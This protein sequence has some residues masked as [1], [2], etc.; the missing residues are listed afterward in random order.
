MARNLDL[1]DC[2]AVFVELSPTNIIEQDLAA[3]LARRA[4]PPAN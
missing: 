2:L 4:S 3:G 1:P